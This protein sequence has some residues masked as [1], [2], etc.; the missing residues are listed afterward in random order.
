MLLT[1]F[2]TAVMGQV[3]VLGL[4][5]GSK[6]P[7]LVG[8]DALLLETKGPSKCNVQLSSSPTRITPTAQCKVGSCSWMA[9][10]Q[11]RVRRST[12]ISLLFG[13]QRAVAHGAVSRQ[14]VG[15]ATLLHLVE[16]RDPTRRR[17]AEFKGVSQEVH[18]PRPGTSASGSSGYAIRARSQEARMRPVRLI[19]IA[20]A[21]L[22]IAIDP[23]AGGPQDVVRESGVRGLLR[24]AT[25]EGHMVRQAGRPGRGRRAV[26][27]GRHAPVK[28]SGRS[29][30]PSIDR[31]PSA[32][33]C[34]P[35]R[36]TST[37]RWSSAPRIPGPGTPPWS[38]PRR[39]ARRS[40]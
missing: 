40:S 11:R 3:R 32:S 33:S 34:V 26:R 19:L 38:M 23:A 31:D 14:H 5:L 12:I 27:D 9:P 30:G 1:K 17:A 20:T 4:E 16:N 36:I 29:S 22:L 10:K 6:Q 15:G 2:A 39:R 8:V 18:R 13:D 21:C 25:G 28:P 24:L 35:G 37:R 7:S